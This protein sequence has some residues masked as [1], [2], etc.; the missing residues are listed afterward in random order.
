M[1]IHNHD[2]V[3]LQVDYAESF[4]TL[5]QDEVQSAH[6]NKN[7]ATVFVSVV[8]CQDTS[9]S[10]VAVSDNLSHSKDSV[11]VFTDK[12]ISEL[13]NS[14]VKVSQLWSNGPSSQYKNRFIAAAIHWFEEKWVIKLCWN[15]FASFY[16]NGLL[17]GIGGTIK[18]IA[19]QKVI[20][21]K[22]SITDGLSFYQTVRNESKVNVHFVSVD[23][24]REMFNNTELGDNVNKASEKPGIFSSHPM[25]HVAGC[26]EMLPCSTASYL[27]N[28]L[29][30]E[31]VSASEKDLD[32][33]TATDFTTFPKEML[34]NGSF[35]TIAYNYGT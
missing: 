1:L 16:G 28:E 13:I 19:T 11:T 17:H 23:K 4:P 29:N 18:R 6:W 26:I 35:V 10:A 34:K 5:W 20:Q 8:G 30:K 14:S 22:L 32:D 27:V 24:I 2:I 31:T 3:V 15:F 25:K 9:K 33:S 21:R 12:L 7:Q